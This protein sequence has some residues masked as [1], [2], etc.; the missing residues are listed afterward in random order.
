MSKLLEFLLGSILITAFTIALLFFSAVHLILRA[1]RVTNCTWYAS[2]RT[3]IDANGDGHVNPGESPLR[4]VKVHVADLQNQLTTVNWP[5]VTDQDGD[6]QLSIS[7]PGCA[8]TIFEIYVDIPEG[9]RITTRPRL[10]VQPDIWGS[11]NTGRVF[12]FGF[13]PER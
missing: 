11:S 8:D 10:A 7:I 13:A 4:D 12:Y 1:D 6:V 2:A 5:A 3:W 9:Y